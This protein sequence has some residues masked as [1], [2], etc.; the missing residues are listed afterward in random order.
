MSKKSSLEQISILT[1]P[2]IHSAVKI[3]EKLSIAC[4]DLRVD[5]QRSEKGHILLPLEESELEIDVCPIVP[6]SWKQQVELHLATISTFPT[7]SEALDEV[8]VQAIILERRRS[9]SQKSRARAAELSSAI[10]KQAAQ[11]DINTR[12]AGDLR[13]MAKSL[14]SSQ[15]ERPNSDDEIVKRLLSLDILESIEDRR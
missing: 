7:L 14:L 6:N 15:L 1:C 11:I 4:D 3:L 13:A 2:P 5:L 12:R 8:L 9:V 10:A